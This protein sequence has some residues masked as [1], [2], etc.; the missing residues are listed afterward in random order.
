MGSGQDPEEGWSRLSVWYEQSEERLWN[1][2]SFTSFMSVGF[3][4]LMP[5]DTSCKILNGCHS[6]QFSLQA[7]GCGAGTSQTFVTTQ[8]PEAEKQAHLHFHSDFR[9]KID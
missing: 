9:N 4:M 6:G 2:A 1:F 5:A 8:G 3:H 7:E